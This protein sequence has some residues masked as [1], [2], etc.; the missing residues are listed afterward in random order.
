M[1]EVV[2]RYPTASSEMHSY[3]T[4][5]YGVR[6]GRKRTKDEVIADLAIRIPGLLSGLIEAGGGS[7]YPLS[8]ERI[9]E[10]V[11]VAYDPAVAGD[12]LSARSQHGGTGLEW[13]DAARPRPSRP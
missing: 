13:D 6:A 1:E 11:R 8:A 3:I 5:T 2:E 10:V 9:A 4:L 7:A 12:V